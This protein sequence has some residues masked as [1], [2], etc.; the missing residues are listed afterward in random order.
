MVS[1]FEWGTDIAGGNIH[2]DNSE[3]TFLFFRNTKL[4]AKRYVTFKGYSITD[5]VNI[6][7]K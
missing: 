7:Y 5:S 4:E 6:N 3:G 1:V 2:V